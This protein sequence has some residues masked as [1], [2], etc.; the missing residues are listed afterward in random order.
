MAQFLM[1]DKLLGL[2]RILFVSLL[3]FCVISSIKISSSISIDTN[4]ADVSPS[5]GNTLITKDAIS[6]LSKSIEKRII[7]LISGDDEDTVFDAQDELS[8]QLEN[9]QS[10]SLQDS[11]DELSTT[12]IE[13]LKPYRFSLLSE[14]QRQAL[15]DLSANEIAAQSKASLYNLSSAPRVYDFN[16]DPLGWHSDTLFNLLGDELSGDTSN[17]GNEVHAVLPLSIKQGA[18]NIDTQAQLSSTLDNIINELK[19]NYA[20]E[21]DRSGVFFFA[22]HAAKSSKQDITFISTFSSIG[23]VL[24]LLIVF[25]SLRA[26][27]LPAV[28]IALGV[29]FA[30]LCTHLI[31]GTVHILTIVFGASLIGIVVD[32]SLHYFYHNASDPEK[33][34]TSSLYKALSFSL[35]TSIIGYTAL[36]FSSLEALQKVAIF[37]CLGLFTAW[38]SVICLGDLSLRKPLTLHRTIFTR[39]VELFINTIDRLSTKVWAAFGALIILVTIGI[40]AFTTPFNDDPRVF[41]KAPESLLKSEQKVAAIANDYEPGRYII[42]TADNEADIHQKHDTLMSLINESPTLDQSQFT[43]LLRWVPDVATQQSNYQLQAKLYKEPSADSSL[44]DSPPASAANILRQALNQ[45]VSQESSDLYLRA[46]DRVLTPSIISELLGDSVP[47]LWFQ[48]DSGVVNFV[49]IKKGVNA[50][51]L[52]QLLK[53]TTGIEYVNSLERTEA[54][55]G[56][57]RQSAS[58]LLLLA[59][60]LVGVL[61]LLYYRKLSALSLLA[62]PIC[63]SAMLFIASTVFGFE[64]NL[65]HVMA[66]FLVLGFGMDYTIFSKEMSDQQDITLEA[67]LL[68]ACTSLLSFGLLSLSSIPVVAS[69]GITLLIGNLFNLFGAFIYARSQSP[70][71]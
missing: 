14:A 17:D 22:S 58:Q 55:L 28:S 4:L 26:L 60:L 63:S 6:T 10:L 71:V 41:F 8:E 67:I 59:Y 40:T 51:S 65:F 70:S 42:I 64:L 25:R 5:T 13:R 1:R 21:V 37:S 69:F 44:L 11:P 46:E 39:I 48:N 19:D 16:D 57:Q 53:S 45:G 23:I 35:M 36:S 43:S 24:L 3:V 68:S 33:S 52:S 38:L 31:Y 61:C 27:L 30:F 18:L 7:L 15:L 9:I 32:Y 20:V 56:S 62:V 12:V 47:P 29:G 50:D 2:C 49:L 54:A 66:L 34:Q